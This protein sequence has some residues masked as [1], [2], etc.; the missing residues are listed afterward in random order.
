MAVLTGALAEGLL[1]LIFLNEPFAGIGDVAGLIGSALAGALYVSL[2]TADPGSAGN[3]GT[4]EVAYP[5]YSRPAVT[6]DPAGVQPRWKWNAGWIT[7]EGRAT[8]AACAAGGITVTHVGIGVDAVGAG[9]LLYR[10]ALAAPHVIAAGSSPYL[11]NGAS[12]I[13][14]VTT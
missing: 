2:H 6:R 3:Q 4:S 14:F 7:N 13:A 8:F 1:R 5:G 12:S 10:I 11:E 9:V